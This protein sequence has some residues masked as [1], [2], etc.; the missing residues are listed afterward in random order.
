MDTKAKRYDR[1]VRVWGA[2]GQQRLEAAR[3]CVLN[4]GPTGCEALKN[5]VLGGVAAFT[6]VDGARVGPSDM[7]NNFLVGPNSLGRPR[8]QVVT[9]LLKELNESVAGSFVEE[10]PGDRLRSD[11][12]FFG[13]F[14]I[15]IATQMPEHEVKQ[16][17]KVCQ[18]K[19]ISAGEHTVI[20]TRP[21]DQIPDLRLH[22]PWPELAEYAASFDL[23]SM[24]VVTHKHVP[25]A[26][27][28]LQVAAQWK[29]DHGGLLPSTDAEKVQFKAAVADLNLKNADGVPFEALSDDCAV[30]SPSSSEFWILVAALKEFMESEG[31]GHLPLEGSLPDM[32]S[33]T[34]FY[35]QL[36]NIYRERSQKDMAAM[37]QIVRRILEGIGRDVSSVSRD[38]LRQFCKNAR[39]VNVIRWIPCSQHQLL[40]W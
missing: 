34:E 16:L 14:A 4:C 10:W 6:V 19:K 12:D 9:E 7:G 18:E 15:V 35:L 17:D 2:H 38:S 30:P 24:D 8:A 20:E 5:L 31:K 36:Q 22:A 32:T 28:L 11:P 3:V 33:T 23:N 40:S 13:S 37:E 26:V 1:Q 39:S 21:D 29:N 25:Y 27:L